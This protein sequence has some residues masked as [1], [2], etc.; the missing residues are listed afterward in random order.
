MV[1]AINSV[2]SRFNDPQF[3]DVP[4]ITMNISCPSK[5]QLKG[6][7]QNPDVTMRIQR[8]ERKLYPNITILSV[9]SQKLRKTLNLTQ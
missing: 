9:H 6:M 7:G 3:N 2:E 8:I 4:G 5:S 1:V